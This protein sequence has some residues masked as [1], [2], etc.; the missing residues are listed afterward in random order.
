MEGPGPG[1]GWVFGVSS[2]ATGQAQPEPER[3]GDDGG[4]LRLCRECAM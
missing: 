4:H 2:V 1:A 3:S